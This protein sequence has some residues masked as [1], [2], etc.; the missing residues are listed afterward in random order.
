M[1]LLIFVY[2]LLFMTGF[3]TQAPYAIKCR[4]I[5]IQNQRISNINFD[6]FIKDTLDKELIFNLID[7]HGYFE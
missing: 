3:T 7:T 5:S 6:K 2:N 1:N 4:L